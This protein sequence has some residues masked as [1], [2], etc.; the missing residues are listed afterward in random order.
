MSTVWSVRHN[1]IIR[2][3][4]SIWKNRHRRLLAVII[5]T[6]IFLMSNVYPAN[7]HYAFASR[8]FIALDHPLKQRGLLVIKPTDPQFATELAELLTPSERAVLT[9]VLEQAVIVVNNTGQYIWGFTIIFS[10][11]DHRTSEGR[12]WSQYINVS[13]GGAVPRDQML[14][15]GGR[16]LVTPMPAVVA[17]RQHGQQRTLGPSNESPLGTV[18]ETLSRRDA[19]LGS[20]LLISV[21]SVIFENGMILGPDLADRKRQVN[22]HIDAEE[23]LIKGLAGLSGLAL[24]EKVASFAATTP[25]DDYSRQLKGMASAFDSILKYEGDVALIKL[26]QSMKQVRRFTENTRIKGEN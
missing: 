24:R 12:S 6:G 23:A 8:K 5:V 26:L 22:A 15:P 3:F 21:D 10:Y 9:P 20:R 25:I 2:L 7:D 14:G 11:P 17:S 4:R 18:A 13:P 16:Y 1:G 19:K